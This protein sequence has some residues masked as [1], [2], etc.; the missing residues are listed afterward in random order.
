MF[1]QGGSLRTDETGAEVELI[2]EPYG[3]GLALAKVQKKSYRQKILL[4]AKAVGSI[5]QEVCM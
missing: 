5:F 1:S 3:T 4:T 2:S